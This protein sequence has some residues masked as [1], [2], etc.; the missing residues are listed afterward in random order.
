MAAPAAYPYVAPMATAAQFRSA[1]REIDGHAESVG[2]MGRAMEDLRSD[3]GVS[4]S[5]RVARGIGD[6]VIANAGTLTQIIA[7]CDAAAASLRQR[8]AVCE[9]YDRDLEV[10]R[11]RLDLWRDQPPPRPAEPAE[12]PRPASYVTA[13]GQFASVW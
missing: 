8:A 4:G 7:A 13:A 11:E 1:A 6:A 9:Q 2:R 3:L 10:W 12:P 5:G